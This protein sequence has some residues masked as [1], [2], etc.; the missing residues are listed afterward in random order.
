VPFSS[1]TNIV[2]FI[3]SLGGVC[4]NAITANVDIVFVSDDEY[5]SPPKCE[6]SKLPD[7]ERYLKGIRNRGLIRR[8]DGT[9]DISFLSIKWLIDANT[10]KELPAR[11][12]YSI[13][14]L[15][16]A[17]HNAVRHYE[18]RMA[19]DCG[20]EEARNTKII[21][22]SYDGLLH[23]KFLF[24]DIEKDTDSA[25]RGKRRFFNCFSGVMIQN[26][27][28]NHRETMFGPHPIT[29][30]RANSPEAMIIMMEDIDHTLERLKKCKEL[31]KQVSD[32]KL[33]VFMNQ[34]SV[35]NDT[36]MEDE[37]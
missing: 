8:P 19:I 17:R 1:K 32:R 37:F 5:Y 10:T 2:T 30:S 23:G 24:E 22:T 33:D 18:E 25:E 34:I 9:T 14:S 26:H 27:Q 28:A 29:D 3:T 21:P 4:S 36:L 20:A 31:V 15:C 11:H 13:Q 12:P 35:A 7:F 6:Q 16:Q